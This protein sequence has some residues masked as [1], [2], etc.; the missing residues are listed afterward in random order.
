MFAPGPSLGGSSGPVLTPV[1][2]HDGG[3]FRQSFFI[4]NKTSKSLCVC[5]R[6]TPEKHRHVVSRHRHIF[7]ASAQILRRSHDPGMSQL[8]GRVF[9]GSPLAETWG[10]YAGCGRSSSSSSSASS[11]SSIAPRTQT[12]PSLSL[13]GRRG[14]NLWLSRSLHEIAWKVV[15]G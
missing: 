7:H 6:K 14:S 15:A 13:S 9:S 8:S 4:H 3:N 5:E 2:Q 1:P 10:T 12:F 11:S